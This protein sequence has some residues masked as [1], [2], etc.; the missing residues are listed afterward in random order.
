MSVVVTLLGRKF[1]CKVASTSSEHEVGLSRTASL[2]ANEG[3]LFKFDNESYRTFHMS[4]VPFPIDIIGINSE[5]KVTRV[6]ANAQPGTKE[7]WGLPK[8]AYVL[9][10]NGG[11]SSKLKLLVGDDVV[12]GE[13]VAKTAKAYHATPHVFTVL[14]HNKSG[15]GTHFGDLSQAQ[16]YYNNYKDD[17]TVE[18]EPWNGKIFAYDLK[19]KNPLRVTH[20][21]KLWTADNVVK[22][23]P[24][25]MQEKYAKDVALVSKM[26]K[27]TISETTRLDILREIIEDAGYDSLVY[28][29]EMT[30]NDGTFEGDSYVV[31]DNSLIKPLGTAKT[32]QIVDESA[33]VTKVSR[34]LLGKVDE[35]QWTPDVLNG[36]ATERCVVTR[37]DLVRWLSS[38]IPQDKLEIILDSM[39]SEQG[40]NLVGNAFVLAGICDTPKVG[41]AGKRPIL[42]LYRDTE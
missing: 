3:L 14:N 31:W 20:L 5:G 11:L 30:S 37:A 27:E 28:E 32:A 42:V 4:T 2:G 35:M 36:G 1:N 41:F 19:I 34:L 8:A 13:G 33:F 16:Q 6:I 22:I 9:E 23:L 25:L 21:T 29:N 40:L 26:R 24:T 10:I 38:D 18:N 17:A 7:A 12:I 15:I 39:A